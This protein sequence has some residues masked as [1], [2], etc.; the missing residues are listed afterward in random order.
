[1]SEL[2]TPSPQLWGEK[3]SPPPASPSDA[4]QPDP[5][6]PLT[7]QCA[8]EP[9]ERHAII[10]RCAY[11]RAQRRGFAPGRELEDWLIAEAEIGAAVPGCA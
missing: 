2:N 6:D 3:N 9:A 1:M 8:L 10:A 4:L 7:S 5:N 11:L